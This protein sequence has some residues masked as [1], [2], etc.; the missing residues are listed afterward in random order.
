[1]PPKFVR[2]P[3]MGK[4]LSRGRLKG[5]LAGNHTLDE[6]LCMVVQIFHGLQLEGFTNAGTI[7]CYIPLI[8]PDTHPLTHFANGALIADYHMRIESPYQSAADEY[9]KRY[10]S[11]I[12]HPF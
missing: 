8:A 10:P 2:N 4:T 7:D 11:I 6:K 9:D 3:P 12:P 5:T 1:M